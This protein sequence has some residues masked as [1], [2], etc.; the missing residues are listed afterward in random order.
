MSL[1][2]EN[3]RALLDE[4]ADAFGVVGRCS[5]LYDVTVRTEAGELVAEFRG[6]SRVIPGT[7]AGDAKTD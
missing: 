6:H 1:P 2:G 7:L 5:G 3:G 4:G